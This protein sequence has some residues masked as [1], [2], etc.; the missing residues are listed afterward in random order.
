MH[1]GGRFVP[2]RQNHEPEAAEL[3]ALSREHGAAL[4]LFIDSHSDM[5]RVEYWRTGEQVRRLAYYDEGWEEP[6]GEAMKWEETLFANPD[7]LSQA[8]D[9]EP[10][11]AETYTGIWER[12]SLQGGS[13]FPYPD[14][15]GLAASVAKELNVDLFGAG[16]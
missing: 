4:Y 16:A 14:V 3:E 1:S 15:E 7:A 8:L 12:R 5:L 11:Q 10:E 13:M 9:Y 6:V 2:A